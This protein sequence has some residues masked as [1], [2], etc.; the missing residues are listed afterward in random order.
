M[1][2]EPV[3]DLRRTSALACRASAFVHRVNAF[4]RRAS[5]SARSTTFAPAVLTTAVTVALLGAGAA[6]VLPPAAAVALAVGR[7]AAVHSTRMI[8][9]ALSVHR[10]RRTFGPCR[11]AGL[12]G[13]GVVTGGVTVTALTTVPDWP[14]VAELG[15]AGLVATTTVYLLG[16]LLLPGAT[17]DPAA[18]L[19][20]LLDGVAA[21]SCLF[22]LARLAARALGPGQQG[23][24]FLAGLVACTAAAVALITGLRAAR[25]RRAA[26]ACSGGVAL[27]VAGLAGLTVVGPSAGPGTWLAAA[28][29]AVGPALAAEGVRR[30]EPREPGPA[31]AD[32]FLAGYPLLVLPLGGALLAVVCRMA[33]GDMPDRTDVLLGL[34]TLAALAVRE[35]LA[36]LV[37][38]RYAVRLAGREAHFRS[39]VAGSRDVTVVVDTDQVVRWLSP[40]AARQ[41]AL[42]EQEA[43]GR[44][45]AALLHP[46][47]AG[48]VTDWLSAPGR[49][50]QP[51]LFEARLRDGYGRW[52][53]TEST[54]SDLRD[55]P[56]VAAFVVHIRD[57][58]DRRAM[59]RTLR[60]MAFTDQL[61][62]LANR[63]ELLRAVAAVRSTPEPAGSVLIIDLDG[64][65][66]VNDVHGRELGDAVLVE[67]G[68]RL[69]FTLDTGDLPARLDGDEFAVLTPTGSV[70]AYALATRLVTVLNEQYRLP[71]VSVRLTARAGLAEVA[72]AGSVEEIL[73]RADLALLRAERA[74]QSCVEWYDRSMESALLR[75]MTLER[76]LPGAIDRGELD[77]V[78]QPVLDLADRRPVGA[79]ALLRWRHPRLGAVPPRELVAVAEDLGLADE[80]GGWA[81]H[82]AFRQLSCWLHEGWDLWMSVN[83]SAC[84]LVAAGFVPALRGALDT[85]LVPPERVVVEV[86]EKATGTR[87]DPEAREAAF[88]AVRAVGV[89]TAIDHFGTDA[90]S[91]AHLRRMAVDVLK[92]DR[93]LFTEPAGRGGPAAPI[94]DVVM[95]LGDRLGLEVIACGLEAEAHLDV[96]RAAGCHLGQGHLFA[97]PGPAERVEAYLTDHRSPTL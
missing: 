7:S 46:D 56:E 82:R 16:L 65:A 24:A 66:G 78:Y 14:H 4:V 35:A 60:Q 27:A 41:F 11:G 39:L 73:R 69:R 53:E 85:H 92:V 5:A 75:R 21:G 1:S 59:E 86:A 81:M 28:A 72:G 71:G 3:R 58:G 37:I 84:Q 88:A 13:M 6:G 36:A 83:V 8:R 38:R 93:S 70:R 47:D 67:V 79:E 80:I 23:P 76:E 15:L 55:T 62:G 19:E 2:T 74:G 61:T 18:R 52:R 87:P 51:S 43:V 12:L 68:R 64:L 57:I 40:A 77:L 48:R 25:Y 50:G 29:L 17:T 91:L 20:R 9:L 26:L 10:G 97:P 42:S 90:T 63:R 30:A 32:G 95:S 34:V 89:R 45:F 33:R 31:A 96:V 54:L 94:M 22:S 44:P 49:T